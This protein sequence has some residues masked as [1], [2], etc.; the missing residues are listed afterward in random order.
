MAPVNKPR[1]PDI[2]KPPIAPRKITSMGTGAP[3]PSRIGFRTLS[4]KDANS[5]STDQT[6]AMVD[7]VSPLENSQTTA[8]IE[9]GSEG[10]CMIPSMRH[11][12][13]RTPANGTPARKKM[14]PMMED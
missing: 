13:M 11:K 4:D 2:I 8:P 10:S 7:E 9:I 12:I 3:L 14:I 6:I 5:R 1:K